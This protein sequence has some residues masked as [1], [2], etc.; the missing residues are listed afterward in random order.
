[1]TFSP[2]TTSA[3]AWR[4][5]PVDPAL[6]SG[7]TLRAT[8]AAGNARTLAGKSAVGIIYYS[9]HRWGQ[10]ASQTSPSRRTSFR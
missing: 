3:V 2:P 5:V 4:M 6:P 9:G 10:L 8:D 1:M 7:A